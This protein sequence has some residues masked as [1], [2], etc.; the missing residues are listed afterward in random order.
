MP[1]ST[2]QLLCLAMEKPLIPTSSST[3][4]PPEH[5]SLSAACVELGWIWGS[6]VQ[7][8]WVVWKIEEHGREGISLGGFLESPDCGDFQTGNTVGTTVLRGIVCDGVG[9]LFTEE[10]M[11]W[12]ENH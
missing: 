11:Q 10:N 5:Q 4:S 1:E 2:L 8:G 6:R 12:E 7:L 9:L 3:G